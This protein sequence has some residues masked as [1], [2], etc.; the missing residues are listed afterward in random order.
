MSDDMFSKNHQ[1]FFGSVNHL[2]NRFLQ[3]DIIQRNFGLNLEIGILLVFK[4]FL[5]I[6][7]LL[8]SWLV[9]FF[10]MEF[11]VVYDELKEFGYIDMA[12]GYV[13][14]ARDAVRKFAGMIPRY[15]G[16]KTEE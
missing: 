4:F 2:F 10:A 6:V 12:K 15:K 1:E 9:I 16:V 7:W 8:P 13:N 5:T 3:K 14:Q 11:F